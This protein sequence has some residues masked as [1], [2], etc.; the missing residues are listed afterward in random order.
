MNDHDRYFVQLLTC[1]INLLAWFLVVN[2]LA[3]VTLAKARWSA[4]GKVSPWTVL[5]FTILAVTWGVL[6]ISYPPWYRH[7]E[8]H[9]IVLATVAIMVSFFVTQTS[10]I[11]AYN[12]VEVNRFT[13][14]PLV[15]GGLAGLG[16]L[17]SQAYL[18][19]WQSIMGQ[20]LA[21]LVL[22]GA[23]V[24]VQ[25]AQSRLRGNSPSGNPG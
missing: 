18:S 22:V 14:K 10:C 3:I 6:L 8:Y 21:G 7:V 17:L 16:F 9:V 5:G 23:V 20:G 1:G 24:V 13:I 2:V 11:A 12:P 4:P 19:G 15:I 25:R